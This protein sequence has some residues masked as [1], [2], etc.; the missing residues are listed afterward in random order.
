MLNGGALDGVRILAR[1]TV[2]FMTQNQL[3]RK[4]GEDRDM[5]AMASFSLLSH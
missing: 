1:K 2:Q 4:V 3:N 5:R